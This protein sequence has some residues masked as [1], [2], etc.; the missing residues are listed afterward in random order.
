MLVA[1]LICKRR[2][3]NGSGSTGTPSIHS[4]VQETQF[5]VSNIS[6]HAYTCN[7]TNDH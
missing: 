4:P 3:S 6:M 5:Y 2:R 7:I 1:V